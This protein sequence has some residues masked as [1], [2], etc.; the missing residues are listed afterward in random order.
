MIPGTAKATMAV[1]PI[2]R[3]N[4]PGILAALDC[5]PYGCTEQM[6]SKALPLLYFDQ[7]AAA[8]GLP[9]GDNIHKRIEQTIPLVLMN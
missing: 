4:A 3:L 9:D 5:Y 7:V 2:A 1:G 8:L 6:T